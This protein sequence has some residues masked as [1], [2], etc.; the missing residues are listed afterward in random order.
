MW[1]FWVHSQKAIKFIGIVGICWICTSSFVNGGDSDVGK[2]SRC[3]TY[4]SI[5][6]CQIENSTR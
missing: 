1:G 2:L 4:N 5:V 6:L 3:T